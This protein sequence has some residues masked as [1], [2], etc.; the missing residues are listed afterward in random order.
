MQLKLSDI[1]MQVIRNQITVQL[2]CW[3][4]LGVIKHILGGCC[5]LSFVP[6]MGIFSELKC[7]SICY[8]LL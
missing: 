5:F 3:Q 7:H 1:A 8:I 6:L 4:L 2:C